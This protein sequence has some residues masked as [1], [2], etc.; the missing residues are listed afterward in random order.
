M[1]FTGCVV[2]IVW[3]ECI[4]MYLTDVLQADIPF[5]LLP[6]FPW[7]Y[8]L[9]VSKWYRKHT[10]TLSENL[11]SRTYNYWVKRWASEHDF[12]AFC[13]HCWIS[14]QEAYINIYTL[15]SCVWRCPVL[16]AITHKNEILWVHLESQSQMKFTEHST[17][18][19]EMFLAVIKVCS[20][21]EDCCCV[22]IVYVNVPCSVLCR[23]GLLC[24]FLLCASKKKCVF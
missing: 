17:V 24:I 19:G 13:T 7:S 5:T 20:M 21:T 9:A 4:I 16:P 12:K 18:R 1:N 22:S 14:L 23:W 10:H 2:F 3:Y 11:S 15:A 8:N 6:V